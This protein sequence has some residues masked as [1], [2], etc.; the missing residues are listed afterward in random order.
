[1]LQRWMVGFAL[2][3]GC[4]M[5]VTVGCWGGPGRVY[6]PGISPTAAADA[7]T[8]Y[9][10]NKD[11]KISGD[12]LDKVPAFK[13]SMA[14]INLEGGKDVTADMIAARIQKWKESKL[15]KMS[16]GCRV[17]RNG[18]PLDGATVTF[19]PEKFLGDKI[20]PASGK[21]DING[22]AMLSVPINTGGGKPEPPG[23]APGFYRIVVTKDGL[24]IPAKYSK[25][26]DAIL[27]QE[28]AQDAPGIQ[29]GL[30]YDL[31]F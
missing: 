10:S 20:Q 4:A 23:V 19:Y 17:T 16:L 11:G 9:D 22:M 27:G 30:K 5:M 12:E 18:L 21:T 7:M 3:A 26:E 1:M 31:R 14:K 8:M 15:G 13:P 29:E 28:V 24:D 2:I 25:V 6:P